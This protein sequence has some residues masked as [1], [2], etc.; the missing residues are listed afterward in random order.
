MSS[1]VKP[2]KVSLSELR[3]TAFQTKYM[4]NAERISPIRKQMKFAR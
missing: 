3:K 2:M 1:I 4:M